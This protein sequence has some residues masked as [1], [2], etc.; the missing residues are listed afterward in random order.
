MF[1]GR[2]GHLDEF[3][4]IVRELKRDTLIMLE[5]HIMMSSPIFRLILTL[6]LHLTLL[7]VLCLVFPM[8]LIIT[9]MVLVH[10]RIALCL[11][12]LI[13]AHILIMVII[14]RVCLIFLLEDFTATL[15]PDT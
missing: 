15:S 3:A 2:A 5:T 11:D 9:H 4:S 8:D 13:M 6:V 10:E 12:A 7:R 14:F 1:C